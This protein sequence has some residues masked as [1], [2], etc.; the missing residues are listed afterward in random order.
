[1]YDP[2]NLYIDWERRKQ[3]GIEKKKQVSYIRLGAWNKP[4][5]L[6]P[7]LTRI[8][9]LINI[10]HIIQGN[11]TKRFEE[12]YEI[13]GANT[14]LVSHM[15]ISKSPPLCLRQRKRRRF[16]RKG[17]ISPSEISHRHGTNDSKRTSDRC[18]KRLVCSS[19]SLSLPL[20][21]KKEKQ[22][23]DVTQPTRYGSC[24]ERKKRGNVHIRG[25]A[26]LTDF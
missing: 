23:R 5:T 11:A 4:M 2:N 9:S 10:E 24:E 16:S 18:S 14:R 17:T 13:I 25:S 7:Q 22:A 12:K 19:L 21:R 1:M 20:S 8:L 6:K 15:R 26:G 3:F